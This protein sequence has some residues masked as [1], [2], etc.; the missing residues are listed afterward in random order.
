MKLKL[1]TLTW[2]NSGLLSL[3]AVSL[4]FA[5]WFGLAELRKPYTNLQNFMALERSAE[6]DLLQSIT[7]YIQEGEDFQL[8]RAQREFSSITALI[9]TLAQSPENDM[10]LIQEQADGVGVLIGETMNNEMRSYA[11]RGAAQEFKST[12]TEARAGTYGQ[13]DSAFELVR[14]MLVA[15]IVMVIVVAITVDLMQRFIVGRLKSFVPVFERFASGDYSDQNDLEAKSEEL[16]TLV[17]STN[18]MRTAMVDLVGEIQDKSNSVSSVS[19]EMLGFAQG[20]ASQSDAQFQQTSQMTVAIEEMS[21]S[22]REVAQSAAGAAVATS[23]ATKAVEEGNQ[24]VQNSVRSVRSLVEGVGRTSET[25]NNLSRDAENIGEVLTVIEGI[26]EQTNLLALNAAIEAARAGEAGRGFAVVADEVRGLSVRT[27]ESTQEIKDIISRLQESSNSC[28]GVMA[29]QSSSAEYA[30]E[31][32]ESAGCR[33]DEIV[34]AI[35]NIQDLSATIAS[36][37]EQQVSV[38]NEVAQNVNSIRT[39]NEESNEIA[40]QTDAKAS[41]LNLVCD[42]LN[43]LTKNFKIS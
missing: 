25:V 18:A 37:T 35:T 6:I 42:H 11:L 38:V 23:Q 34:S 9:D 4:V 7:A 22:F 28:V 31:Q 36:A 41:D 26:A 16:K 27:S 29:E 40:Q 21:A 32:T 24:L 17:A 19:E 20:L 33:L 2:F 13:I 12:I 43:Q 39:L 1:S 5:V 10:T 30:A 8:E 15:T 3:V 14:N